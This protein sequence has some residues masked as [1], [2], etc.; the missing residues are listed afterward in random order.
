MPRHHSHHHKHHWPQIQQSAQDIYLSLGG[1]YIRRM[2]GISHQSFW[3]LHEKLKELTEFEVQIVRVRRTLCIRR[4]IRERRS[5][6]ASNKL[7]PMPPPPS[8]TEWSISTSVWLSGALR[9]FNGGYPYD[10]MV[11]FGISHSEILILCSMLF[12]L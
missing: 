4:R 11:S 2:Y 8:I 3:S 12:M 5:Y 10:I 1:V 6:W 7:Y 9:Y